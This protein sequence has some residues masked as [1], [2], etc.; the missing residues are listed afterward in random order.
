MSVATLAL[1]LSRVSPTIVILYALEGKRTG[2]IRDGV[3]RAVAPRALIG[4]TN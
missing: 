4:Q 3:I 2:A 1:R